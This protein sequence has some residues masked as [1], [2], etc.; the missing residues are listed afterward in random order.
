[1]RSARRGG[2]GTVAV[3]VLASADDLLLNDVVA[4]AVLASVRDGHRRI[5]TT[6]SRIVP[7]VI[8]LLIA[9]IPLLVGVVVRRR[10]RIGVPWCGSVVAA[11]VRVAID[12]RRRL[13]IPA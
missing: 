12:R 4:I 8:P 13:I 1:M 10:L 6:V 9:V 7:A 2:A 11:V 3:I 5:A